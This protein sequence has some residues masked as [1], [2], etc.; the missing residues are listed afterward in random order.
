SLAEA[1]S[2]AGM[3]HGPSLYDPHR[4]PELLKKRRDRVL[5]R[6]AKAGFVTDE[7]RIRAQDEP[8]SLSRRNRHISAPHFVQSLVEQRREAGA[9]T[10]G[11]LRTSLLGELQIEIQATVEETVTELSAEH[12]TSTSVV[13]L[14]NPTSEVLAYVG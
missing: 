9:S 14:D 12:V 13:V 11:S 5:E 3:P 4:R 1:A 8:I 10:T 7:E 6:M 2:L